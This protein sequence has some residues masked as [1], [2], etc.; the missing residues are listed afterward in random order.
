[1]GEPRPAITPDLKVS[2]L[3]ESYP[4]LEPVLIGMSPSFRALENPLLRRTVARLATLQQVARVG[5]IGLGT[6]VN[7]LREAAG[8]ASGANADVEAARGDRPAWAR[9]ELASRRFDAREVIAEG[10]HPGPQVMQELKTLAPGEVLLLLTPFV[11]APLV[12]K[13]VDRGF[14][15]WSVVDGPELALTYFRRP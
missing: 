3:L 9:D 2:E 10:G 11:P 15:A 12:D 1:M 14:E 6:L 13:A 8:Q 4:E 7:R 5:N